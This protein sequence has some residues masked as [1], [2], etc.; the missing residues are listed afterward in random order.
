MA[1]EGFGGTLRQQAAQLVLCV[2]GTVV[3]LDQCCREP[4]EAARV[5]G[6]TGLLIAERSA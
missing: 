3:Q 1:G 6:D 4:M 5:M 2:G